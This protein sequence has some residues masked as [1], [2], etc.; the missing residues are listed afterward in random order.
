MTDESKKAI[1]TECNEWWAAFHPVSKA[2]LACLAEALDELFSGKKYEA[3]LS[4]FL[5]DVAYN[6]RDPD[7]GG[8]NFTLWTKHLQKQARELLDMRE[9]MREWRR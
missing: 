2:D 7:A 1:E 3:A 9:A 8:F 4:K 5:S 6:P